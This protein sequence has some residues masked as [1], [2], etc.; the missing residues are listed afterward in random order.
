M[1]NVTHTQ[2][3]ELGHEIGVHVARPPTH[4]VGACGR[5][6]CSR[7]AAPLG[8]RTRPATPR[9]L[10]QIV[11]PDEQQVDPFSHHDLLDSS[12]TPRHVSIC[13]MTMVALRDLSALWPP[14][15]ETSGSEDA[16]ARRGSSALPERRAPH[17]HDLARLLRGM[18]VGAIT[19]SA[20]RRA[21]DVWGCWREREDK[22]AM[23]TWSPAMQISAALERQ[24]RMLHIS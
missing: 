22:G 18:D 19:P 5:Q 13:T 9:D 10:E 12:K 24:R 4:S 11:E 6:W 23:P 17:A 15:A 14:A 2:L 8:H 20:P 7:L 16:G 3:N 21:R 1:E